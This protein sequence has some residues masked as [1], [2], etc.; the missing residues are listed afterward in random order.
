MIDLRSRS[1]I[2]TLGLATLV[3]GGAIV[4]CT[5][6]EATSPTTSQDAST[7]NSDAS[8]DTPGDDAG[9][10]KDVGTDPE[11]DADTSEDA[12]ADAADEDPDGGSTIDLDGGDG[13]EE[14]DGGPT[15]DAGPDA[16]PGACNTLKASGSV[17]AACTTLAT[18]NAGGTLV[19]GDY[20]LKSVS[21]RQKDCTGFTV[22]EH[23]G[24]LDLTKDK[25]GKFTASYVLTRT[26]KS[27]I[28]IKPLTSRYTQVLDPKGK[29]NGS[30]ATLENVCPAG[31][32]GT[33]AYTSTTDK[34]GTTL[35]FYAPYYT[36]TALYTW[37]KSIV[38]LP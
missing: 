1:A 24:A 36:T 16:G 35:S 20:T 13:E 9:G 8:D 19:A 23:G 33:L 10:G 7:N 37:T 29:T 21:V 31:A 30:P 11:T 3:L 28:P 25:D 17:D 2:L 22:T 12:G 27:P 32:D 6:D 38:K 26:K 14:P 34:L 18:L 15:V 4:A 5:G